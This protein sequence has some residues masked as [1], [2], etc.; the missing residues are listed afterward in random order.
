MAADIFLKLGDLKG[1]S[2][3]DKH[4]D[5]IEVLSWSWGVHQTGSG[6]HTG[7]SG[8]GRV[9]VSDFTVHYLANLASPNLLLSCFNGKHFKEATL[10]IRKAGG[11]QQLEYLKYKLEQVF[12]SSVQSG[13][14]GDE[15]AS[16]SITLNFEKITVEY[17]TQ[18]AD[19]SK[20]PGIE[21][22]LDVRNP[23]K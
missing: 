9:N 19:G 2:I 22:A 11:K 8:T 5:E 18:K 13:S 10:A 4:K 12:I 23:Y 6:H 21:V 1:E 3:D 17:T 16:E 7:G 14:S 15:H 20:G